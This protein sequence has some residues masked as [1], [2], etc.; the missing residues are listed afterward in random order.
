MFEFY[1]LGYLYSDSYK[2]DDHDILS[3]EYVFDPYL[4][5]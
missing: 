3:L 1:C 4:N 5:T 2:N